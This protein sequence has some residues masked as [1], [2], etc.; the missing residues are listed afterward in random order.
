MTVYGWIFLGIS[1]AVII[2]LIIFCFVR[3]FEEP[4]EEL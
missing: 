2:S 4:E 3:V 1:W